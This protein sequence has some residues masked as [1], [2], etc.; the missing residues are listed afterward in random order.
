M[1]KFKELNCKSKNGNIVLFGADFFSAFPVSELAKMYGLDE[2]IYNRSIDKLTIEQVQS[3]INLCVLDF[4]P[5]KVFIN[6]GDEDI[7]KSSFNMDNFISK[8]EWMLY[9]IHTKTKASIYILPVM[10]SSPA[11]A[12]LNKALEELAEKYG[13]RYI[14]TIPALASERPMLRV[15]ELMKAYLR[16][17]P[18]NFA[19]AMETGSNTYFTND[20]GMSSPNLAGS[21]AMS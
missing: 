8:Y 21:H 4:M 2:E 6:I 11:A 14:D 15:F 19:D 9:T 7:K 16:T 20:S 18:I 1:L 3:Y 5:G 13:C 10:S 12:M 17:H